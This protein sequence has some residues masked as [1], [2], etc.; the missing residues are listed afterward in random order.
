MPS[1]VIARYGGYCPKCGRKLEKPS[2]KDVDIRAE[3]PRELEELKKRERKQLVTL[4]LPEWTA[5]A[6]EE[7]GR[8]KGRSRG[9][10]I[11]EAITRYLIAENYEL[12]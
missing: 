3:T 9:E 12:V 4:K 2:F 6:L 10:L 11:R 7:L 1:E 5:E 8:K